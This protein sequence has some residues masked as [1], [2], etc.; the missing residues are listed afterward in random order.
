VHAEA[1]AVRRTDRCISPRSPCWAPALGTA[2]YRA[3]VLPPSELVTGVLSPLLGRRKK[4]NRL[5]QG[6]I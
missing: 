5:W 3:T 1:S 2:Q 4:I 6:K